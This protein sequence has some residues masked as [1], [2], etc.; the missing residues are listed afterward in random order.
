M[1]SSMVQPAQ[2]ELQARRTGKSQLL[3]GF[4]VVLDGSDD[5]D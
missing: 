3:M 2:A 4:A 1:D 5:D